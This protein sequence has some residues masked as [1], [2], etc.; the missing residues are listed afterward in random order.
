MATMHPPRP[1]EGPLN[2]YWDRDF[3]EVVLLPVPQ[4]DDADKERHQFYCY[5]LMALIARYCNGNKRGKDGKYPGR[6]RQRR[7]DGQYMGGDYLGHNIAAIA[8]DAEGEI[9]DFDFN[10][11]DV[12]NSSV[13]HAE[14]RLIRRIFSLTSLNNGW[15]MHDV[16]KPAPPIPYSTVLSDVTLYTSLE[17]C[18]Q[19]SG[20]MALGSLKDVVFLQRDPGQYSIGNILRQLSPVNAR[21]RP[22][23]PIPGDSLGMDIFNKLNVGYDDF[24][25]TL[26]TTPFFID[27]DGKEDKSPSITSFLCTDVA[28]QLFEFGARAMDVVKPSFPTYKPKR[29]NGDPIPNALSNAEVLT[30]VRRFFAYAASDGRRGTPHKL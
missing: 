27:T 30:H 11:N 28:M 22:P 7:P 1:A 20:I 2:D 25:K 12:L 3:N 13:E 17:S 5:L 6:E 19:C 23:R 4:F 9:I 15:A 26:A 8:V 21:Y 10:H 16:G 24:V 29:Q 18:A 14:S